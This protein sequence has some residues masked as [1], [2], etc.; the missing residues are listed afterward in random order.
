[1][2]VSYTYCLLRYVHDV[3]GGEFVN[4]GVALYA[5]DKPYAGALVTQRY[6]RLSNLFVEVDGHHF[7]TV[8]KHLQS[9]LATLHRAMQGAI[10]HGQQ[11]LMLQPS[12]QDIGEILMSVLPQDDSSLQFS[13]IL[14]GVTNDPETTLEQLFERYIGQYERQRHRGRS[15]AEVWNDYRIPLRE[16]GLE[17]ILVPTIVTSPD[18]EYEF[19]RSWRNGRLKIA[20]AISFD[21]IN[22]RDIEDK[23]NKWLGRMHNLA[24]AS[25]PF[26]IF[27][28][29]GQPRNPGLAHSFAR[30]KNFLNKSPVD[31]EFINE[32][33][34]A[35]LADIVYADL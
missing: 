1:M 23:A 25:E 6:A 19:E 9:Q 26:T 8:T 4:V 16:R 22:P 14:G 34:G 33:E 30:A 10:A 24:D 27:F 5:P 17:T 2:S 21:L 35:R 7:R 32:D 3:V 15:D 20:E 18:Y 28:L 12:P 29:L 31:H 13:E 11:R